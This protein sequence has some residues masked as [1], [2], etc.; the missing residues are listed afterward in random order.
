MTTTRPLVGVGRQIDWRDQALCRRTPDWNS[1]FFPA[2]TTEPFRA[3]T[4]ETKE[5]CRLCPVRLA[6]ATWALT[7]N[8][9]F[10]I[11]GGL[12]E[13]ERTSIRRHHRAELSDPDRLRD[14]LKSRAKPTAR[15][16]LVSAYLN[17]TEQEEDGHVRW[18]SK[19]TSISVTGRVL[20]PAQLAYEI[21]YG[22]Q[23]E[24][25]VKIRCDRLGCV[26]AEHLADAVIRRQLAARRTAAA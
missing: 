8:M 12:D 17:R 2:G 6:C 24:G 9:E 5:F 11:W 3:V 4:E 23:P 22:R 16:A 26:A 7:R 21:G 19:K 13:F 1:S 14:Y 18:L 20:T 25:I 15:D 10:G